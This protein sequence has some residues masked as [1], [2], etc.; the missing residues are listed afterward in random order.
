MNEY[1]NKIVIALG[2]LDNIKNIKRSSRGIN[3][4]Y[5]NKNLVDFEK[6]ER[7]F[8]WI[9]KGD[10]IEILLKEN[11]DQ[12]YQNLLT[13]LDW[14]NVKIK[15]HKKDIKYYVNSFG[16]F[17]GPIFVPI[18]PALIV[19]GLILAI[20]NLLV[21]YFGV[22][23]DSGAAYMMNAVF[24]AGLSAL[25]IY[26][27]YTTADKLKM[28]PIMGA[29][30]GFLL[31][32]STYTSGNITDL[33]GIIVPQVNYSSSIVPVIL[34][35]FLMYYLDKGF[36]RIIPKS[37][38]F[39]LK[40]LLV[41]MV[42]VPMTLIIL[43][44]IGNTLSGYVATGILWVNDSFG[45]IAQPILCMIYPYMVML[46]LDKALSPI[47][48]QLIAEVG[49]NPVTS[50][51]GFVSNICIGAS[52]L[53]IARSMKDPEKRGM[54]NSFGITALCGVTEPAFYGCLLLR[55]EALKGTA[56]GAGIAGLFAGIFGLRTFV[57]GGCPGLL[58]LIFFIDNNGG[59]YYVMIALITAAIAIVIS[60]IA[61][62]VLIKKSKKN[63]SIQDIKGE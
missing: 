56:I 29:L 49:Y 37:L 40:P 54:N 57:Q 20:R 51:M 13:E 4:T 28:Q 47:G 52:T 5:S 31:I 30:L 43:G 1:I 45:F 48:I 17:V 41:I 33:F 59:F 61:T 22:A 63:I 8:Y 53:A 11:A 38:K 24:E 50:I 25:P 34:G 32:G 35:V 27:G 16:N 36:D 3:I 10:E 2:E 21:N 58:T 7:D 6:L 23:M 42:T 60:Y 12:I 44:P 18:I 39:F 19:G 14:D 15:K 9:E 26:I 55:P 46:G 62:A